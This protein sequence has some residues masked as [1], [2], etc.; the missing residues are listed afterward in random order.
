MKRV[1]DEVAASAG[2]TTLPRHLSH[3]EWLN[4]IEEQVQ[5]AD[6]DDGEFRDHMLEIAVLATKAL[7]QENDRPADDPES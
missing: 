1:L 4:L 5:M 7:E 3:D 6:Y 2:T